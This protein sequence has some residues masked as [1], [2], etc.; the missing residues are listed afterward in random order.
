MFSMARRIL[1]Y[2][3][4]VCPPISLYI[5][6]RA[7]VRACMHA[8]ARAR[9]RVCV[10]VFSF[11]CFYVC[12]HACMRACVHRFLQNVPFIRTKI[13][14]YKQILRVDMQKGVPMLHLSRVIQTK[15]QVPITKLNFHDYYTSDIHIEAYLSIIY[16]CRG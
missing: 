10:F 15:N 13:R 1:V 3:F 6:M 4:F 7:C 16:R 5:Y 14:M 9:A 11:V 12:V 8:C 2:F